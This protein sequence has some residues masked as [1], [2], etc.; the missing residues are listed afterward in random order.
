MHF[1][2]KKDPTPLVKQVEKTREEMIAEILLATPT[3]NWQD[4][5]ENKFSRI[6]RIEL[7]YGCYIEGVV[8]HKKKI[9]KI[10]FFQTHK[11]SGVGIGTKLLEL[12]VSEVKT[13]G[14]VKINDDGIISV[15]GLRARIKFFGLENSSIFVDSGYPNKIRSCSYEEAIKILKKRENGDTENIIQLENDLTNFN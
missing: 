4:F 6:L 1:V 3:I 13:N 12:F 8:D 14:I 10:N 7:P 15:G 5:S 9:A 11:F 2:E